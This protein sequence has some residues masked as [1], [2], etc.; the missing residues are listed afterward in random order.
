MTNEQLQYVDS[1][2]FFIIIS[3]IIIL[4]LYYCLQQKEYFSEITAIDWYNTPYRSYPPKDFNKYTGIK[5][6]VKGCK[7]RF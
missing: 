1:I 4:F 6:C 3:S 5:R 2:I 7:L